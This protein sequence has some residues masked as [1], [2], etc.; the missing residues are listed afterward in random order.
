MTVERTLMTEVD[1]LQTTTS[2]RVTVA[3]PPLESGDRLTRYE[4]ERRYEAMPQIKKAE[5][6]EGVVYMA[7]AVRNSH[8]E[9][10]G[11]VIT[12][13]GNYQIAPPGV[14]LNDNTT[15]RL[16]VDNEP[17]PDALLRL[18]QKAG[19]CSRVGEDDYIEGPPELIFEV[20]GTSASCD[21]HDKLS[22]YRRNGVQEYVVWR[23]YEG[24]LNWFRLEEG[25]YVPLEV[26]E[27]GGV[28]SEDF[29]G[30]W[31]DALAL[32]EG[33]LAQVLEVLQAGLAT[34][35]HSAFVEQVESQC[36]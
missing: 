10:R 16:D 24:V 23:I 13:L 5:L 22:A 25:E 35:E 11:W 2:S 20:A 34:E 28:R 8:G 29:P 15:V 21:L 1:H 6:I 7:S 32:L 12:W 19:G 3:P 27:A 30:L 31:L 4:F 33:D 9:A 36:H 18:D 17:Q 14:H 26:D